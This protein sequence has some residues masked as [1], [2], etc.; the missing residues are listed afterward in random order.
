MNKNIYFVKNHHLQQYY[1]KFLK[2]NPIENVTFTNKIFSN[3]CFDYSCKDMY[4]TN[5]DF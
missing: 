3:V 5:Y 4:T 2:D 1:Y